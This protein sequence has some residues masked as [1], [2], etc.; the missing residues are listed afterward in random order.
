M[1][2]KD[3]TV[4]TTYAIQKG[5]NRYT[6]QYLGPE[7]V[8][9][10]GR[11]TTVARFSVSQ[12]GGREFKFAPQYIKGTPEDVQAAF[13]VEKAERAAKALESDTRIRESLEARYPQFALTLAN[14]DQ[15]F[16][17]LGLKPVSWHAPRFRSY[18]NEWVAP[19]LHLDQEQAEALNR[20]L[21]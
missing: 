19:S 21:W 18:I 14:L 11:N 4:G 12:Y 3:L 16:N 1:R 6:G 2:I 15:I 20:Y 17:A 7:K 13:E 8:T 10:C 5:Y 9:S